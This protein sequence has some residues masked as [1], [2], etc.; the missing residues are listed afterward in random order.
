[1][2][3][4]VIINST[5]FSMAY[6]Y[7]F[8]ANSSFVAQFCENTDKPELNCNG[9]CYLTK[10]AAENEQDKKD[11]PATVTDWKE[12][13]FYYEDTNLFVL[14]IPQITSKKVNWTHQNHYK[15][16]LQTQIFHPPIG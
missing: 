14:N 7:Y 15:H 1:M 11:V 12:A 3:S 2:V 4:L 8:G 5:K 16:L 13:F 6:G 9:K 10:L